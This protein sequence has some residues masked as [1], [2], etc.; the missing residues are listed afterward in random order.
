M[1][2]NP[3]HPPQLPTPTPTAGTHAAGGAAG[4]NGERG[5]RC[6]QRGGAPRGRQRDGG[7]TGARGGRGAHAAV[8]EH[9][10]VMQGELE[11]AV[12]GGAGEAEL[13]A[14]LELLREVQRRTTG[15]RRQRDAALI[16]SREGRAEA[17][18][19]KAAIQAAEAG[20]QAMRV[21]HKILGEEV[22]ALRVQIAITHSAL[23]RCA[24]GMAAL[25]EEVVS[26]V[27]AGPD[28]A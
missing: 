7:G 10:R 28:D 17:D 9:I 3:T 5:A 27:G 4:Q 18:R 21:D 16:A 6:Q 19:L 1:T 22:S 26:V 2:H 24:A 23:R 12:A 15:P 14:E 8:E 13:K 25:R 11:A 20:M